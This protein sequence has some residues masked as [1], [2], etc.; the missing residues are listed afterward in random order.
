M[1]RETPW[2]LIRLLGASSTVIRECV[3]GQLRVYVS[4]CRKIALELPS[5]IS[6]GYVYYVVSYVIFRFF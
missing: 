3:C 2:M 1:A 6:R 5:V 4:A